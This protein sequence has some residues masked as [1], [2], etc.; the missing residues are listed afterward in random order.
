MDQV[1]LKPDLL[2]CAATGNSPTGMY[3]E[4]V[5]KQGFIL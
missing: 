1:S 5:K 4:M 2:F 3:A